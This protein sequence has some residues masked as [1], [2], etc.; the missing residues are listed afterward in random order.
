LLDAGYKHNHR[1]PDIGGFHVEWAGKR[2]IQIVCHTPY[3]S[4]L[5][6]GILYRLL[7]KFHPL[8]TGV[9]SVLRVPDTPNRKLGDDTCTFS[10]SW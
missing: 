5:E 9:Y 4:D 6:Y 3:P 10:V 8:D 2:V 7:Q 1:G